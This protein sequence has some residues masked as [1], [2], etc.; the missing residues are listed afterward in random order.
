[1]LEV[2]PELVID[3]ERALAEGAI[4]PWTDRTTDYYELLLQ[5]VSQQHDI[6][7]DRPWKKLSERH[8][9]MLLEGPGARRQRLFLGRRRGKGGSW[10]WFEGVV[11]QLRRQHTTSMSSAVRESVEQFMSLSPCPECGGARLKPEALAVT[12]GGVN[13]HELCELSVSDSLEFFRALELS[14]TGRLI[15]ARV[16]QEVTERLR[17]L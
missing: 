9:K 13:I 3:P 15:G 8:R 17:F 1:M 2:D 6:P 7:L 5:A 10:G 16:I 14:T 11:P 12:V 4:L